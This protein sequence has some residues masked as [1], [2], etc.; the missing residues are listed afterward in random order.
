MRVKALLLFTLAL[1]AGDA[2]AG[3]AATKQTKASTASAANVPASTET[4]PDGL[5]VI[6]DKSFTQSPPPY[7]KPA[8]TTAPNGADKVAAIAPGGAAASAAKPVTTVETLNKPATPAPVTPA[9]AA[10]IAPVPVWRA[11]AG[12]TLRAV[13]ADWTARAG[14]QQ[15]LW[16]SPVLDTCDFP[17]VGDL[18]YPG[19]FEDAVSKLLPPYE[20]APTCA[21]K[22][23][24]F[25]KQRLVHI[26]AK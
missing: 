22:G 13:L 16:D 3:S 11:A 4:D 14:Y 8:P 12:S 2:L 18:T 25:T 20:N 7:S 5:V 6:A 15:P 9:P 26:E 21:I 10:P 1:L 17:I 24:V 23:H 19:S